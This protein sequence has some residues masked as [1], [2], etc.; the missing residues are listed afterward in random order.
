MEK[1]P[2]WQRILFTFLYKLSFPQIPKMDRKFWVDEKCSQCSLL[3]PGMP[4]RKY[5]PSGGKTHLEPAVR[6]V[7]CLPAMVS[8]RSHS[9]WEKRSTER[10]H[11]PEVKLNDVLKFGP[12]PKE[13]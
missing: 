1:G 11:H 7:F 12:P 8:S 13:R 4:F 5:Y 10:Y 2:L 6:T 9:I 3:Q